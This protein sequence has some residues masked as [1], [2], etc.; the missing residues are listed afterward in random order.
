MA[1][2]TDYYLFIVASFILLV[3]MIGAIVLTHDTKTEIF[4]SKL[5]VSYDKINAA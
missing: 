1:D 2:A 3:A 5:V 4:L